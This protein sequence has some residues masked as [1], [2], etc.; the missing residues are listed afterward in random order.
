MSRLLGDNLLTDNPNV[1]GAFFVPAT[2]FSV[3][4]NS[5]ATRNAAGDVSMN[6]GAALAAVITLPF[7]N[8]QIRR[9]KALL[10]AN[11]PGGL[12]NE[13]T[14]YGTGDAYVARGIKYTDVTVHYSITGAALPQHNLRIDRCSF[15]NNVATNIQAVFA[16][17]ANGL[18]TAAQANPYT[19]KIALADITSS[20]F[21]DVDN[22]G[23]WIEISPTT[24]AG[25]AYRL[26][27]FTFHF[28]FN[29]D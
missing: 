9:M 3:S 10:P 8:G 12:A 27:G 4:T 21:D 29:L 13:G 2:D 16:N 19:T 15:V 11:T 18:A 17:G 25:G 23:L 24:Q 28:S 1:E 20:K 6:T 7:N 14:N 5:V 26:Y 22:S